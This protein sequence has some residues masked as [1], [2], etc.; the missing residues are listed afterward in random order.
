MSISRAFTL[1]GDSNIRNHVNKNTV[2]ANPALK[3]A[4]VL[5]CGYKGIFTETLSKVRAESSACIVACVTNF[6]SSV[7]GPATVSLR[8]EPVL[9]DLRASLETACAAFPERFYLVAPPMYRTNPI[10]YREGLPEIMNLFSLTFRGERPRNLLLLPSFATPDYES[11]GVHLTA[12]SGLEFI[13]HLFD[14]SEEAIEC[15]ELETEQVCSN[16]SESTR[17]LEDRVMVLEQDHR[18]LAKVVDHKIAVDA[19]IADFHENERREN[20]FEIYGLERISSDLFGKAWQEKAIS[21]VQ[22]VLQTPMGKTYEIIFIQN[23]TSRIKVDAEVVYSVQ[24]ASLSDC[25]II[26]RKFGSFYLGGSDKRPEGLTHVN[27]KNRVTP[28]TKTRISVLKLLA[29]RY[30]SSNPGAKVQ[31]ISYDPRPLLK[32]TPAAGSE[33]RRVLTYN[34]VEAVTSLP[35]NFSSEE[36]EPILK[37]INPKLSGQIRSLFI[38]LSD[39]QFSKRFGKFQRSGGAASRPAQ[40]QEPATAPDDSDSEGGQVLEPSSAQVPLPVPPPSVAMTPAASGSR[41]GS[42]SKRGASGGLCGAAKK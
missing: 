38:C 29:K 42:G 35:T 23:A 28:E 17:V 34:Y 41:G 32:I 19:E 11:D 3:A 7:E 33:S 25:R 22:A 16:T 14:S 21:D 20:C 30:R 4:Q 18:R 31:V 6:I 27:I 2:R 37:R 10:W 13:L 24:M 40:A 9:Q 39:D 15:L 8:V 26:R 36:V 1:I 12:Y 5:S